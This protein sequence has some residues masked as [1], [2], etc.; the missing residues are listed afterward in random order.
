MICPQ[1]VASY[2]DGLRDE[3]KVLNEQ[4]ATLEKSYKVVSEDVSSLMSQNDEFTV[5]QKMLSKSMRKLERNLED[6][7]DN[8][9]RS[10]SDIV[11]K[12]SLQTNMVDEAA[13]TKIR[14]TIFDV[15]E[16]QSKFQSQID[17]LLQ[18]SKNKGKAIE[19]VNTEIRS[20]EVPI[21]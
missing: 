3:I 19:D 12:A 4:V 9:H 15:Q 2:I 16:Q 8:F 7:T 18:D 5:Q 20:M 17:S 21:Y 13:I 11:R 14:G 10:Q 1:Q 6:I